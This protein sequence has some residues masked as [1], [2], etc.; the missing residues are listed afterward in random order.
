MLIRVVDTGIEKMSSIS[1]ELWR[2]SATGENL[3]EDEIQICTEFDDDLTDLLSGAC[4]ASIDS[5]CYA[6]KTAKTN[7]RRF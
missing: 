5:A 1:S 3:T 7:S 6:C 2:K 4:L